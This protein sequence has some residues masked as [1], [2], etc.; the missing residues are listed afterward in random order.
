MLVASRLNKARLLL[1]NSTLPE[2]HFVTGKDVKPGLI[3]DDY[4][5]WQHKHTSDLPLLDVLLNRWAGVVDSVSETP[6]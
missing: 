5:F 3:H 1:V 4:N 6:G 2:E